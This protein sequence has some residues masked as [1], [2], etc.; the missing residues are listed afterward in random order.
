MDSESYRMQELF[1]ILRIL[2]GDQFFDGFEW[3]KAKNNRDAYCLICVFLYM[4]NMITSREFVVMHGQK[5]CVPL[6]RN[7]RWGKSSSIL[8]NYRIVEILAHIKTPSNDY[9]DGVSNYGEK[10]CLYLRQKSTLHEVLNSM[11]NGGII[12]EL[13]YNYLIKEI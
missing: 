3:R 9:N 11:Y 8:H 2:N 4:G 7:K 12:P 6:V 1:S 10:G 5:Q 13:V